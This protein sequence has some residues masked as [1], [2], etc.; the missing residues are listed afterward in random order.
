MTSRRIPLVLSALP[1]ALLSAAGCSKPAP[2][3]KPPAAVAVATAERRAAPYV[4]VANGVVEP[5]RTVAVQSQVSGVLTA[6]H[7][8][9][10]DEVRAGQPL[11]TIDPRPYAAALRQARAVLARDEAQAESARRE[12]ERFAALVQKDYVTRSQADQ[13]AA[14]AAALRA[15]LE[16]DR[17]AVQAAQLD[18]DN[19]SIRA[20][21]AGKTGGLLVREGNLVRPGA[22]AP[23]VVINQ[24][25][26][27]LVRFAVSER[28]FPIVQRY[29]AGRSLPVRVERS[30]A[31]AAP[32][33]GTLSFVDNGID[34]T[35][36]TV[37]LKARF[38]NA[39]R[40]LWP[41][42]FVQV[43]LELFVQPDAVLVPG[44]A[45]Q[46]GQEGTFVFVVDEKSKALMRPVVAGR[47]VGRQVLIEK[48][49]RGGERVVVDGQARI[50]PGATVEVR[51][52]PAPASPA[53]ASP[54][55]AARPEA[56][57]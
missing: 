16:A 48:G 10:G 6:V 22:T 31:D 53:P 11:F 4:V 19:A 50:A 32:I 44:E 34:T 46:T 25:R 28:D 13:A 3:A 27:T 21:V 37:T 7:F 29:A 55:V 9:E 2:A 57:P 38:D 12:A 20:P 30:Q 8:A 17:G 51:A 52:A 47:A 15:M 40:S 14:N 36:G 49:L 41:G 33:E 35:T 45:V 56:I 5:M 26:P 39:A 23:L 24:I 18:L 54:A 42:Q 1:A 43:S